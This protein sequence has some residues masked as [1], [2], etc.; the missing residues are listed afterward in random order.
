MLTADGS[1]TS[2]ACQDWQVNVVFGYAQ[3]WAATTQA[4]KWTFQ[5]EPAWPTGSF[6]E[7][8]SERLIA[9]QA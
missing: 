7:C 6:H 9:D 4:P 2:R 5:A 1:T 8:G 3:T